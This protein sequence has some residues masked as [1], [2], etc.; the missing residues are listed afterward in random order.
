M[1]IHLLLLDIYDQNYLY[2][3]PPFVPSLKEVLKR[4]LKKLGTSEEEKFEKPDLIV[5]DGGKGQLSSVKQVFDELGI[6]DIDL[7]SLAE[8]EEEIFTLYEKQSIKLEKTD[9]ALK[10]LI[11]L[12]DEA[13]RFAIT[14]NRNLRTKRNLQSLL[15][16]INGIGKIKRNAL[17]DEF[18]DIYNIT[19]ASIEELAR[20]EGI[21]EKLAVKIKE[22]L[23]TNFTKN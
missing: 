9:Q 14:F 1:K 13:H 5:V 18:K 3:Q 15:S 4:R 20:V 19:Q 11:R 10:T 21:G 17:I 16:Q 12:R 8:R 7:I 22:F 6:T 23:S 2:P